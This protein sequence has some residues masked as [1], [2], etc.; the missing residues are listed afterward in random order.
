MKYLGDSMRSQNIF[1]SIQN[2]VE[3]SVL[4]PYKVTNF[5]W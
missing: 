4:I 2:L 3:I 1:V 5:M